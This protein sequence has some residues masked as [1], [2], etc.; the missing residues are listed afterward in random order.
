MG[1]T[2]KRRCFAGLKDPDPSSP[3]AC[4]KPA[5]GV[6][7]KYCSEECGISYMQTKID[8]WSAAGGNK[9]KL[10]ETV[11]DADRRE[12]VVVTVGN[13]SAEVKMEVDGESPAVKGKK[14]VIN[15]QK[16]RELARLRPQL[17]QVVRVRDVMKD[18]MEIVL[19]R[20]TLT[21]LA[22]DRS[23]GLDECGWDQRLC[24]DD[25][26]YAEAG[27]AVLESYGEEA[28]VNDDAEWWCR[29]KKKCDRHS[30]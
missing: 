18:E 25:E 3:N 23:E 27:A 7:S 12:G 28:Q 9:S 11:K 15:K 10:W 8:T 21:Q 6:F 24:M 2:Y 4:H 1:T 29:G 30:G 5:Q 16:E 20:E 26:D 19:W 14:P 17:D 13:T 22:S